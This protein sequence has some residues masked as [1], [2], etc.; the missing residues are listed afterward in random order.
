M[1][2]VSGS[3]AMVKDALLLGIVGEGEADIGEEA[4]GQ[5]HR[6]VLGDELVGGGDGI[7]RLARIVP[8]DHHQRVAVDAAGGIDLLHRH[9]PALAIGLGE[10]GREWSSW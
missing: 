3:P 5:Q 2:S 9:L 10:G 8:G 7:A 6:A 4:A 1:A